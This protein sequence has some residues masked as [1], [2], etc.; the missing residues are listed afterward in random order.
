MVYFV[1]E[2]AIWHLLSRGLG[3]IFRILPTLKS[4]IQILCLVVGGEKSMESSGTVKKGI[5][6]WRRLFEN[7]GENG[8]ASRRR[9]KKKT[10]VES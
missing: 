3:R 5:C 2:Q 1:D 10:F 7:R 9:V 8:V 6:L 4:R